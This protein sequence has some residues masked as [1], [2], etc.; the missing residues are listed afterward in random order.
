VPPVG[1]M[2]TGFFAV[3]PAGRSAD[4]RGMDW[5]RLR[6]RWE[7]SHIARAAPIF[8][9]FLSLVVAIVIQSQYSKQGAL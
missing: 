4:Q 5:W 7:Y 2:G 6:D 3:D 1:S 9:S 8:L